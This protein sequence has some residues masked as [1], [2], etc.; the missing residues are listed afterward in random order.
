MMTEKRGRGVAG[1][2]SWKRKGSKVRSQKTKE[3]TLKK[4]NPTFMVG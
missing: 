2:K 4:K 1:R 3:G